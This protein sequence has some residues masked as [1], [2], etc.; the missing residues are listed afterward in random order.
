MEF[1]MENFMEFHGI[2]WKIPW[3]DGTIFAREN[4]EIAHTHTADSGLHQNGLVCCTYTSGVC[5]IA[6]KNA[7]E[8]KN[9][10]V[11]CCLSIFATTSL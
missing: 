5:D 9:V 8:L 10:T 7:Y 6:L 4:V 11:F 2:P 3:I 1:S